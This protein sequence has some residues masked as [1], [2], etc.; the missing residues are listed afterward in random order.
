MVEDISESVYPDTKISAN[1]CP[2][3]GHVTMSQPITVQI[4]VSAPRNSPYLSRLDTL[5][6]H[7]LT[8]VQAYCAASMK[9]FCVCGD[10]IFSQKENNFRVKLSLTI[11]SD[12]LLVNNDI[13]LHL[14]L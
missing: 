14:S 9:Y 12:K 2:V 11:M 10:E 8:S 6:N 4:P 5:R 3:S 13:I 1:H 7:Q